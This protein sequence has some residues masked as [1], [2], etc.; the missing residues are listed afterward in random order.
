MQSL[1]LLTDGLNGSSISELSRSS[2]SILINAGGCDSGGEGVKYPEDSDPEDRGVGRVSRVIESF[3]WTG[4]CRGDD[5]DDVGV[6]WTLA[7]TD[8]KYYIDI[9]LYSVNVKI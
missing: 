1:E 2:V 9:K 8:L 5:L 6:W 7:A 3:S 4:W